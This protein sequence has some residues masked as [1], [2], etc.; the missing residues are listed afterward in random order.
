MKELKTV[1]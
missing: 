1:D